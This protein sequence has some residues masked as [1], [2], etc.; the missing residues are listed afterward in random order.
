LDALDPELHTYYTDVVVSALE[1]KAPKLLEQFMAL[2]AP[3]GYQVQSETLKRLIAEGRVEGRVEG[4]TRLLLLQLE[5]KF[6]TLD[7][8]V[9][10][11][12]EFA[13]IDELDAMGRRL[14][15]ATSIVDVLGPD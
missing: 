8:S 9:R 15:D 5:H 7:A 6:G 14:L 11:R 13:T 2:T 12:V 4:E 3:P 1:A 10:A